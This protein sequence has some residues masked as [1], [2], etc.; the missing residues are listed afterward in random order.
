MKTTIIKLWA[1]AGAGKSTTAAGL[2]YHM[3]LLGKDVE[4]VREYVKELVWRGEKLTPEGQETYFN[5]QAKREVDLIGKVEYIITDSPPELNYIYDKYYNNSERML[6]YIKQY[7][8]YLQNTNTTHLHFF[9]ERK[10]PYN[11]KGRNETE[12]QAR[13]V[14]TAV[15]NYLDN[16]YPYFKN[17]DDDDRR[18]F[19]II[20]QIQRAVGEE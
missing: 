19:T 17:Q 10:K 18:V 20:K 14:D 7:Q 15:L 6:N 3:K 11:P 16:N 1:G 2:F 4:L 12:A 9:L 13:E 5:T 8:Q